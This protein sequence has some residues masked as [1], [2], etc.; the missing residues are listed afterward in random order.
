MDMLYVNVLIVKHEKQ[1]LYLI[2][3]IDNNTDN[4]CE[5][6]GKYIGTDVTSDEM[7]DKTANTTIYDIYGNKIVIPAGFKISVENTGYTK[8]TLDVTKGIVITDGINEFVWIPVENINEMAKV[9]SG[10]FNT[11]SKNSRYLT[12]S[13]SCT[14]DTSKNQSTINWELK[15][16][17]L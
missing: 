9:T 6:C 12:F 3:H 14:Q 5:R 10:S 1:I 7:L 4:Y 8:D 16:G 13:W 2:G 15:C 11:G 17:H